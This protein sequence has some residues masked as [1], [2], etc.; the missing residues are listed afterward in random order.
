[1]SERNVTSRELLLVRGCVFMMHHGTF[2]RAPVPDTISACTTVIA[3]SACD[4]SNRFLLRSSPR[5]GFRMRREK[6]NWGPR[7]PFSHS[8]SATSCSSFP[9]SY[10]RMTTRVHLPNIRR[11]DATATFCIITS[12][13]LERVD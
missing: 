13:S 10:P 5:F 11:I 1:M 8:P 9:F 3:P 6:A 12:V 7:D 2:I 4:Y